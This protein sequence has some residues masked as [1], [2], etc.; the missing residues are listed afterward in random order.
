MHGSISFITNIRLIIVQGRN[1]EKKNWDKEAFKKK[2]K[3]ISS[4]RTHSTTQ[5]GKQAERQ[6]DR[7]TL[8]QL[9]QN[10]NSC[11]VALEA[12][13]LSGR[14]ARARQHQ[15]RVAGGPGEAKLN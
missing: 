5:T 15:L 2:K 3:G 4:L 8:R 6:A 11:G 12:V 13:L 14:L 7:E 9:T 1:K 10:I